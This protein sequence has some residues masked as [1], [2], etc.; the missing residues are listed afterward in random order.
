[1]HVEWPSSPV[2]NPSGTQE[3]ADD[4]FFDAATD[5]VASATSMNSRAD[6]LP[7]PS[8]F[9]SAASLSPQARPS[10]LF[11]GFASAAQLSAPPQSQS[12]AAPFVPPKFTSFGRASAL[13]QQ[14]AHE[15]SP[16]PSPPPQ[17][18]DYDSWFE[19]D[20][21]VLPPRAFTFSTARTIMHSAASEAESSQPAAQTLQA[22]VFTSGLAQFKAASQAAQ[23]ESPS[24]EPSASDGLTSAAQIN[25]Q[26]EAPSEFSS[27]A[28][29]GFTSAAHMSGGGKINWA[30]P[31]AEALARAAEKMKQWQ[32]EFDREGESSA[33]PD[34]QST[35]NSAPADSDS[36]TLSA[37]YPSSFK[38]PLRPA[39]R[40]VENGFSPAQR[41]E[42][43]SPAGMAPKSQTHFTVVAGMQIKNKPFKSPLIPRPQQ[44][45]TVSAPSSYVSSPL[46]P[47]RMT[48][49]RIAS[50][51]KLPAAFPST[52]CEA[53]S[54]EGLSTPVK[55]PATKPPFVSPLPI[56]AG[57]SAFASPIKSLGM[58][59]R[60]MGVSGSAGK[61]KF[62]TPFKAGMAPG[63]P[64]R[65]ELEQKLREERAQA[66]DP[67]PLRIQAGVTLSKKGKEKKTYQFFDL[68][69]HSERQTLVS[70]RL[71][72]MSYTEEELENM[73]INVE[74]LRQMRPINAIYYR[75]YSVSESVDA[76]DS[77][78]TEHLGAKSAFIYL[79][80]L[81]CHLST[82][83]WVTNHYGLIL[84]KLAGM[85]CLEPER[86][87]DPH[88]RRWCWQ[89]VI[90][91]LLYRY[92][93][94]LNGGVRPALRLI[95]TED[96]PAACPMVLCVSNIV[97]RGSS[98]VNEEGHQLEAQPELEVT[99]GWY[100]LRANVDPPLAR[101]I[102]RGR[103]RIGTKLA[104]SGAKLSGDRKEACEILEA[105]DNTYLELSGNSTNLAPWHAKLGFVKEPFI[106]TMDKLTA[107]G[108]V[109]PAMDVIITKTYPIAFVEFIRNEDG[110]VTKVGPRD[111]KEEM[112][113][114]DQWLA[115]RQAHSEKITEDLQANIQSL[116]KYAERL[117]SRAG[118]RFELSIENNEPMP[119]FIEGL[120]EE[121]MEDYKRPSQAWDRLD[122]MTAG[123]LHV[124]CKQQAE[125]AA[126]RL[127]EDRA[128]QL[129]EVCPPRNVRDFRIVVAKDA[130]WRK[131]EPL[132]T[133]QITLWDPLKMVFSESGNPGEIKE[134][135][136]FLVT[137]LIPNQPS[138]WMAPGPGAVVY[139]V[140]KRTSRWTN[141]K[142][143]K[144]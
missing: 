81:G 58:T 106:A 141:I 1:M 128:R 75:F 98:I 117:Y 109:V 107:D 86:E 138:A 61:S 91:Q 4:P 83:E 118:P 10:Q 47:R 137:N 97:I 62:S 32:E 125:L 132:R 29:I 73:G 113:V 104:V 120:F 15:H 115:K 45:R 6:P 93:R 40:P 108:G 27:A 38:T 60:R 103:I 77:A 26:P 14:L 130:R 41:P 144:C 18:Q 131:R 114:H 57:T 5:V 25:C 67:Q 136:R 65:S 92:E 69:P 119:D 105:Y 84:W 33:T 80:E 16:S 21:S 134:G 121:M 87:Q 129:Q 79:K 30:A 123:W 74:E 71:L 101:A 96:A 116:L 112:K 35:E 142:S 53:G 11:A 20:A 39:L 70:S 100:R 48:E 34:V 24:Q 102:R 110:S 90:R 43:P 52:A 7:P 17:Q 54:V 56:K 140:S 37:P 22:S 3:R 127:D 46:N 50:G 12:V 78:E 89:E 76:D 72:P 28:Q 124:Y 23:D 126:A 2:A 99:D 94:E 55:H 135:Q 9:T 42:T 111:E 85:V 122:E 64:G 82:Q 8:G 19:S 88:T 31:S 36:S 44:P 63:E 95:S 51:S 49:A 133:A 139:L 143:A 66:A 59:P 68:R 13:P